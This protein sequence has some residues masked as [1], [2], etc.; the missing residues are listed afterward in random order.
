MGKPE[1]IHSTCTPNLQERKSPGFAALC[2]VFVLTCLRVGPANAQPAITLAAPPWLTLTWVL[3]AVSG[4]ILWIIRA[5]KRSATTRFV[6]LPKV[7]VAQAMQIDWTGRKQLAKQVLTDLK[8]GAPSLSADFVARQQKS[9][10]PTLGLPHRVVIPRRPQR[11]VPA[12]IA[13]PIPPIEM[14]VVGKVP[15]PMVLSIPVQPP[16]LPQVPAQQARADQMQDHPI[17]PG[18]APP[19]PSPSWSANFGWEVVPPRQPDVA[20]SV[21]P[22]MAPAMPKSPPDNRRTGWVAKSETVTIAGRSIA[23][24]IYVA[25]TPKG[26]Y[27]Q[28]IH[29]TIDPA[30]PVAPLARDPIGSA[31][32]YWPDYGQIPPPSRASYL[33]WLAG[34]RSDP[35][36]A[37]GYVFLYFYGIERRFF[38]DSPAV[39]EQHHLIAEVER[40]FAIYGGNYSVRNYLMRFLDLARATLSKASDLDDLAHQPRAG[41]LPIRLHLA[42]SQAM[43]RDEPL[44]PQMMLLWYLHYPETAVRTVTRRAPEAFAALFLALFATKY[45]G[46]L[47]VALPKRKLV[48]EY[49]AASGQFTKLLDLGDARDISGL[50]KP[51]E[52]AEAIADAACA[53]LDRYSRLIARNDDASSSLAA[54]LALPPEIRAGFP[55]ARADEAQSWVVG[56]VARGGTVTFPDLCAQFDKAPTPEPSKRDFTEVNEMLAAFGAGLAPDPSHGLRRPKPGEPVVLY[57]LP[58]DPRP[59]TLWGL[60]HDVMQLSLLLGSYVAQADGIA[61]DRERQALAIRIDACE[62]TANE[63]AHLHATLAWALAVEPDFAFLTRRM[64][65]APDEAKSELARLSIVIAAADGILDPREIALVE[66]LHRSLGLATTGIYSELHAL[67]AQDEPVTISAVVADQSGVA[68]PKP[69]APTALGGF[70]L[71]KDKITAVMADTAHVSAVLGQIFADT[72]SPEPL[73]GVTAEPEVMRADPISGLDAALRAFL[74]DVLARDHWPREDIAALAGQH[75]LMLDGAVE[76]LNEWSYGQFDAAL[77]D[78]DVDGLTLNAGLAAR[79][80]E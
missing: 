48:C 30:L 77:I 7:S 58:D 25:P 52:A 29:G 9:T 64:K 57:A 66:R 72:T 69:P 23:G 35:N 27:N 40:L 34:D 75:R 2:A 12:A 8:A 43:S 63:R 44:T 33:D 39:S 37:I 22:P 62:I 54:H 74:S 15:E 38:Q 24:M 20:Q 71:D 21:A 51:L 28:P 68:I 1:L 56:V 60:G 14:P 42:V 41:A 65:D 46:G 17:P 31:F 73:P 6:R 59:L 16:V 67:A 80:R 55:N 50:I 61:H 13:K 36:T 53:R 5:N 32:G 10:L 45:T 3:L 70:R 47:T 11:D 18:P 78:D 76:G 26:Q 79:L 19:S 4:A 49:R